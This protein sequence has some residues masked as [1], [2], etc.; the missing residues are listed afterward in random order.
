MTI[1]D[2]LG[3]PQETYVHGLSLWWINVP[4]TLIAKSREL[5]AK[6]FP[7]ETGTFDVN[8]RVHHQDQRLCSN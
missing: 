5:G 2:L 6:A 8:Y 4:L 1:V 3:P 7:Q